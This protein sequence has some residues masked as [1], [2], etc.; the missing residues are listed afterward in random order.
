MDNPV[1]CRTLR[2]FGVEVELNT[3]TGII[4]KWDVDVGETPDGSDHVAC[5]IHKATNE[6]VLI[7]GWHHTHNNYLWIV[8]SDRSCGIEVCSPVLKGWSGQRKMLKTIEIFQKANLSADDKCSLHVH[9][10]VGDLTKRQLATVIAYWI[11]CEHVFFDSVPDGRKNNRYCQFIGMS[12]LFSHDFH[13]DIDDLIQRISGVKYYS[14]NTYHLQKGG[15]M[16]TTNSRRKTIEFRIAEN[17]ICI[18]PWDAKNWMRLVLHFVECTKRMALPKSYQAGNPWSGLLWLD[19]QDVFRV[20][21]FDE[22]LSPGLTQVKEWFIERL[23]RHGY[24]SSLGGVWSNDGRR[25]S[26]DNLLSMIGPF[27]GQRQKVEESEAEKL[28]GKKYIL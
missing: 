21:R 11:K 9:T 16:D 2:R 18:S 26:R 15:G 5:L 3:S 6:R 10:S 8:K 7:H 27:Y 14:L 28:Y 25:A 4:K 23:L 22:E 24:N 17:N 1:N 13:M 20:L 19:P 12:D